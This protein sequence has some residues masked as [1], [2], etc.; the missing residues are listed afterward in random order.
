MKIEEEIKEYVLI[1]GRE[2]IAAV[3]PDDIPRMPLHTCFDSSA[4][5]AHKNRKYRYVE[6]FAYTPHL[7]VLAPHAWLTDGIYAFD[8]TWGA[9][10]NGKEIAI[11]FAKYIGIE[12]D[13]DMVLEF[14]KKTQYQSVLMNNW[15]APELAKKILP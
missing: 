4:I 8:P 1:H 11:P 13:I 2:Y 6:G 5:L 7:G 3:R 9:V 15:R 10:K 14:M 12:L